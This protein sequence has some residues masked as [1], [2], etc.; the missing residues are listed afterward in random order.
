M[1]K[2]VNNILDVNMVHILA[3]NT[4]NTILRQESIK[5][6]LLLFGKMSNT[7]LQKFKKTNALSDFS[8]DLQKLLN[9]SYLVEKEKIPV[10][11]LEEVNSFK[12]FDDDI[13]LPIF[14]RKSFSNKISQ[15]VHATL[16]SNNQDYLFNHILGNLRLIDLEKRLQESISD[17]K[18]NADVYVK[19]PR[20]D[21]EKVI[22]TIL[23]ESP[24]LKNEYIS[25]DLGEK[26]LLSTK[27]INYVKHFKNI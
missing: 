26:Y 4:S 1:S 14:K 18:E 12:V 27:D 23:D 24:T 10:C 3:I 17:L 8:S 22:E 11:I 20:F 6:M 21:I 13:D 16:E 2:L 19:N 5:E 9:D 25:I 7:E 15:L